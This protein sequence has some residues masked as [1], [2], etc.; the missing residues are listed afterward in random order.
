MARKSKKP[1][2]PT[3]PIVEQVPIK[4]I[5]TPVTVTEQPDLD[6]PVEGKQST[7]TLMDILTSNVPLPTAKASYERQKAL[8][9]LTGN[10]PLPTGVK[11]TANKQPVSKKVKEVAKVNE[12][13]STTETKTFDYDTHP[14]KYGE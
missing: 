7:A 6:T 5:E 14:F 13:V 4:V 10:V 3:A 1:V 8:L 12:N 2:N 11:L 9:F